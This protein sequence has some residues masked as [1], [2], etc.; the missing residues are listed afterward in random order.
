M[1]PSDTMARLVAR[2]RRRSAVGGVAERVLNLAQ[3]ADPADAG[4]QEVICCA[5]L[6]P[7]RL[8]GADL[9]LLVTRDTYDLV[10]GN[11]DPKLVAPLAAM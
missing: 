8:A 6:D 2:S 3:D 5:R 4:D 11:L 9:I 7:D 10:V 1:T